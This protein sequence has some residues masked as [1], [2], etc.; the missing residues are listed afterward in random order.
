MRVLELIYASS[1]FSQVDDL[2]HLQEEEEEE[3]EA[4]AAATASSSARN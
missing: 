2:F 4:A 1:G 3:E